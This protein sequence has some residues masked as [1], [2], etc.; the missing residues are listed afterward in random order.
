MTPSTLFR[1]LTGGD[2]RIVLRRDTPDLAHLSQWLAPVLDQTGALVLLSP[3]RV[4]PATADALEVTAHA[5]NIRNVSCPV[6]VRFLLSGGQVT[7]FYL[8]AGLTE[9]WS[10]RKSFEVLTGQRGLEFLSRIRFKKPCFVVAGNCGAISDKNHGLDAES[11]ENGLNLFTLGLKTALAPEV[12]NFELIGRTIPLKAGLPNL[13]NLA[14]VHFSEAEHS[15]DLSLVVWW[16]RGV[17]DG[18]HIMHDATIE[19]TGWMFAAYG[20]G[21]GPPVTDTAWLSEVRAE[22]QQPPFV[23]ITSLPDGPG[24]PPRYTTVFPTARFLTGNAQGLAAYTD[25]A[26]LGGAIPNGLQVSAVNL[27]LSVV[28][29]SPGV[30]QSYELVVMDAATGLPYEWEAIPGVL[31]LRDINLTLSRTFGAAQWVKADIRGIVDLGG[32]EFMLQLEASPAGKPPIQSV[33][34]QLNKPHDVDVAQFLEDMY[35]HPVGFPNLKLKLLDARYAQDFAAN[36]MQVGMDV[37]GHIDL[38]GTGLFILEEVGFDYAT[39]QGLEVQKEIRGQVKIAGLQIAMKAVHDGTGEWSF[40][41]RAHPE[42]PLK[43]HDVLDDLVERLDLVAP[44]GVPI[45]DVT[46]FGVGY[47]SISKDV[48]LW[49]RADWQPPKDI[50]LPWKFKKAHTVLDVVSSKD[51]VTTLRSTTVDFRW[52]YSPSSKFTF[53]ATAH[54]EPDMT[55]FYVSWCA[56][57]KGERIGLNTLSAALKLDD[58]LGL[59]SFDSWTV[60][61]FHEA[62]VGYDVTNRQIAASTSSELKGGALDWSFQSGVEANFTGQWEAPKKKDGSQVTIGLV[63]LLKGIGLGNELALPK[64][65]LGKYFEFTSLTIE[66]TRAPHPAFTFVGAATHS[67]Y[68]ETFVSAM[69]QGKGWGFVAGIAFEEGA[70]FSDI[71]GVSEVLGKK[72][73]ETVDDLLSLEASFLMVSTL[74]LKHFVPPILGLH[75]RDNVIAPPQTGSALASS[76]MQTVGMHQNYHLSVGT[77][78]AGRL[79]LKDSGNPLFALAHSL[80]GIDALDATVTLGA[81]PEVMARIPGTLKIPTVNHHNLQMR[82]PYFG[83]SIAAEGGATVSL[84]GDVT[85]NLFGDVREV[86]MALYLSPEMIAASFALKNVPIPPIGPLPGVIFDKDFRVEMAVG[87]EPPGFDL[88]FQGNFHI[89]KS[90]TKYAGDVTVVLEMAEGVINPRYMRFNITTLS[91]WAIF[92]AVTGME[93]RIEEVQ[94]GL[95][96]LD[97]DSKPSPL[98]TKFQEIYENLQPIFDKIKMQGVAFHWADAPVTLPD[99]TMAMP[100]VGFKGEM[101]LFGF[102]LYGAFEFSAG[103][104]TKFAAHLEMEPINLQHVFKVT[105]DG[106]GLRHSEIAPLA[107]GKHKL[108]KDLAPADDGYVLNPGG[109]VFIVNSQHA[110]FLHASLH[111]ALFDAL[112]ADVTADVD[113]HGFRFRL[114][115]D[116][117]HAVNLD[118][119]CKLAHEDGAFTLDAEGDL[120]VHLN[121][122]FSIPMPDPLPD[123]PI[124]ID[125]GFEA[126]VSLHITD[127]KFAMTIE[128]HLDFDGA[129]VPIPKLTLTET[130]PR[131]GDLPG[132]LV[133]HIIDLGPEI[134]TDLVE[135]IL[136][137][138]DL[139]VEA[140]DLAIKLTEARIILAVDVSTKAVAL[141]TAG[142]SA[143]LHVA[144]DEIDAEATALEKEADDVV[145]EVNAK[146]HDLQQDTEIAADAITKVA[147]DALDDADSLFNTLTLGAFDKIPGLHALTEQVIGEGIHM[148]AELASEAIAMVGKLADA[149]EAAFKT[150]VKGIDDAVKALTQAADFIFGK[151]NSGMRYIGGK[152]VA[153]ANV[154]GQ[155]FH[156]AADWTK[157]AFNAVGDEIG[158]WF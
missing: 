80:I 25:G 93:R 74:A 46:D 41:G 33:R 51:P 5:D 108:A 137:V 104:S 10:F 147:D 9:T 68:R 106:K 12:T 157:G 112:H 31:A 97:P 105:G 152:F 54:H 140:A 37:G 27:A 4:G 65:L 143:A 78:V 115:A 23:M 85:I 81:Q 69:R 67:F 96:E 19:R 120:S 44:P 64:G 90:K 39:S 49:G 75:A 135:D 79:V 72:L 42:T 95:S 123:I 107:S 48:H 133:D 40:E 101:D 99:G 2:D 82:A 110:P 6:T 117:L 114:H 141:V 153:A 154:I 57:K 127:G 8:L 89:G 83:V 20:L 113:M 124:N 59:P 17:A 116:L 70:E 1:R 98:L 24:E 129:D 155:G 92:E 58:Y 11:F 100:G 55:S 131:L 77:T 60:F 29:V 151:L 145:A 130:F 14:K 144:S 132:K 18:T 146:I 126:D 21:T 66:L 35:G 139:A 87:L 61:Q 156:A 3:E 125:G 63:S 109:P 26:N 56:Q 47:Y 34:G 38:S 134:F 16:P 118:I 150:I 45:V 149:A 122:D 32:Y 128:G 7:G 103:T 13:A 94:S 52:M 76:V 62:S 22:P 73:T 91:F 53:E 121:A 148:V 138:G 88:G 102:D 119:S 28:Q 142:A 43:L 136:N 50:G 84:G 36:T 71:P 158:S 86:D 30:F 111:V 15:L